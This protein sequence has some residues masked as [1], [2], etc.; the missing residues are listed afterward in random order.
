LRVLLTGASGFIGTAVLAR[1]VA[2]GH[3]VTAVA[4]RPGPDLPRMRRVELDIA[5]ATTDGAWRPHLE[6][7]DAVVNCA[8]VLQDGPHDRIRGVHVDGAAA[9]FHAC[10]SA[11]VRR[12]LHVSA[13]GAERKPL[14]SFSA[15]KK[16]GEEALMARDLDWVIL[17][18]SVVVGRAAYGGSALIR[19]VAALPVTVALPN[20]GPIQVV[21]LDD[22]VETILYFISPSAPARFAGDVA[23]PE[24]LS[25]EDVVLTYRRWLRLGEPRRLSA[26]RWLAALLYRL[27]DL[28][29]L[30]GWRPPLRTNAR[31]EFVRGAIGDPGHWIDATGIRPQSLSEA[32][33]AEPASVQ[34]RWFARL[35]LL[36]PLVIAVIAL[37]WIVT[38]IVSLTAG[39]EAG[40][41]YMRAAGLEALGPAGIVAGALAD[42]VIGL[43]VAFRRTAKPALYA[44]LGLSVFYL[45]A[46]TLLLPG[47]WADP[48]GPMMKIWP[49]MV[50]NL[51]AIAIVE[52]R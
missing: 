6:G 48:V 2:A 30:F 28:A 38:G 23:G 27:G 9:L 15:T 21:Q 11:G 33:A 1:L 42:I 4:R 45:V 52:D 46:G 7:I 17:R 3:E 12:V 18:P 26:P 13:I 51:V 37:F 16:A 25:L 40:L 10:E 8:G 32:L 36:K 29:G 31:K 5:Q 47:L 39:W 35:Y 34:E 50:L 19:G 22:L 14:S 24:R 44:G 43:G 41:S 49:V 20:T